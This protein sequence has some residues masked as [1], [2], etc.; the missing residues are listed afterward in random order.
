MLPQRQAWRD[1]SS[2]NLCL[3]QSEFGRTTACP[4]TIAFRTGEVAR[5]AVSCR[6]LYAIVPTATTC[7]CVTKVRFNNMRRCNGLLLA[8]QRTPCLNCKREPPLAESGCACPKPP[9][10]TTTPRWSTYHAT[11][12]RL[13]SRSPLQVRS[14]HA[15]GNFSK[16]LSKDRRL[17]TTSAWECGEEQTPPPDTL[18]DSTRLCLLH[19]DTGYIKA[20]PT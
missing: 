13:C 6:V 3:S 14:L 9:W 2:P 19:G 7:C 15:L 12:P 1:T 10:L 20:V 11:Q 17:P 5:R 4:T 8:A 16:Q 18:K